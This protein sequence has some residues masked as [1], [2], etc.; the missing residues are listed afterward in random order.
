MLSESKE[1]AVFISETRKCCMC[2]VSISGHIISY[3]QEPLILPAFA[4]FSVFTTTAFG[5]QLFSTNMKLGKRRRNSMSSGPPLLLRRY[6]LMS[7]SAKY[8]Y[9]VFCEHEL[10]GLHAGKRW[11]NTHF[12]Q[13]KRPIKVS[14]ADSDQ[15]MSLI[16]K[17]KQQKLYYCVDMSWF[18]YFFKNKN[19]PF[20]F[21]F[22]K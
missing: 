13:L 7:W 5:T 15:K 11:C 19:M 4:T 17:E 2:S 20:S 1:T 12:C 22:L 9:L 14:A 3:S 16:T 6:D 18:G 21:L 8:L 10:E